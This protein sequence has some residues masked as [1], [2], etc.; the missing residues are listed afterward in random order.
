M[1]AGAAGLSKVFPPETADTLS[2]TGE[3]LKSRLNALGARHNV[4]LQVTGIGSILCLHFQHHPIHRPDDT[5]HTPP[6][7]RALCHLELLARNLY[8]AR[9]GFLTLSLP[10][11]PAD[12][13]TF[14]AAFDDFLAA[15]G[16][17]LASPD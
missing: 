14:V 1:A 9:R 10:L 17:A 4:P 7:A 3:H 2:A 5:Q 13:D 12:Y 16:P 8:T 15:C 6:A 11:T